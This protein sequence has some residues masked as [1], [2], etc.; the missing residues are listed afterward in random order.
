MDAVRETHTL[1][2]LGSIPTQ[3]W[4]HH[5]ARLLIS[6]STIDNWIPPEL[7]PQINA[8]ATIL[9][10]AVG[11]PNNT[12]RNDPTESDKADVTDPVFLFANNVLDKPFLRAAQDLSRVKLHFAGSADAGGGDVYLCTRIQGYP[13]RI[14]ANTSVEHAWTL[15]YTA[16][17]V[18]TQ[19][20]F[21]LIDPSGSGVGAPSA[22]WDANPSGDKIHNV[23]DGMVH[24]LTLAE[25]LGNLTPGQMN[26]ITT[27]DFDVVE[28]AIAGLLKA[29]RV[30]SNGLI[31]A[32]QL[33]GAPRPLGT[34]GTSPPL[35]AF[36]PLRS[37]A[38]RT[39]RWSNVTFVRP[40]LDAAQTEVRIDFR[41]T[42]DSA[43]QV[44]VTEIAIEYFKYT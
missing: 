4:T 34:T 22:S 31:S 42:D 20:D 8:A 3:K 33:A 23:I 43:D 38:T 36:G 12:G 32:A 35:A 6:Q 11:T 24:T 30:N 29:V 25:G 15:D 40:S 21:Y 2:S 41:G 16:Q 44:Y 26:A 10:W 17:G 37:R 28:A 27:T 18:L 14:L 13:A 9:T 39:G 5:N 1:P 19:Q 7:K